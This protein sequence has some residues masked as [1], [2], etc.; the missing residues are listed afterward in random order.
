M[1]KHSYEQLQHSS[2]LSDGN[3]PY[4]EDLYEE[5]LKDPQAVGEKWRSYFESVL[6]GSIRSSEISRREIEEQFIQ[7]AKEPKKIFQT[8]TFAADDLSTARQEAVD[9]LITAYRRFGHLNA[10]IDPLGVVQPI[11]SRLTLEHYGLSEK[12]FSEK[13]KTRGL[14]KETVMSLQEI[15][16]ALRSRYCSSIGIEYSRI[17]D[18]AEREWLC[19]YA[20]HR[21]MSRSFDPAVKLHILKKLIAAEGL[22]KHLDSKYPGV[23]RFSAEG[24]DSI[25]PL[26]DEI[27]QKSR[28][29]GLHELVIGMAHRGRLNVLLNI[30][31]QSPEELFQEFEGK[32]DYGMTT[33][34]V[35]YHR[36]FSSDVATPAGPVHLSLMF[37]PSHLE[38]VNPVVIGSVRGRQDRAPDE[39]KRDYAMAILIHG[40]AAFA[41]LGIV[42]E[43]LNM[44]QTRA[45]TTGGTIHIV[46]NNQVGFTTSNAQDSRSSHYC[47]DIARMIDAPIV[48]VNGDDPEAVVA[49]AAMALEYRVKFHKD[50]VI[51]L[52][53]YRRHG[54]QE[55][56]EPRI[57]QPMMYQII[58]QHSSPRELY[59]QK[60][61]KEQ[62]VTEVEANQWLTDYRNRL[63][64]GRQVVETM[65][66]GLCSRYAV[67]WAPFLDQNP[68]IKVDTSVPLGKIKTLAKE[69][70]KIPSHF[71]LHRSVEAIMQARQKMS[72]GELP[73]DWG[74]A[75]IMAYATL[76]DQGYP[77]RMS[78]ED[79]RRG[80]FFHRHAF[81][82]DQ[83]TGAAY[84]PLAHL[85]EQQAK[86]QI[87]DSV[88]A[89]AGPMGF[90]YGYSTAEPNALVIW[91]AQFGDFANVAQVIIDQ[92]ISSGWQKWRRLS[93]LTLFLPHGNEGL[94]PEHSSARLERFLQLCAQHNMQVFIPSTPA[95]MF[96][97]LR[98]QVLRPLRIPL[99]VMTPKS[100]LRHKLSVSSL[101]DLVKDQ[102]KLLI[103][104][105]D[106]D[107]K[108]AKVKRVVFCSGKIYFELLAMRREKEIKDIALV[109]IEQLYPFP[110]EEVIEVMKEYSKAKEV[111]WCQDEPKNQGA[112]F[113]TRDRLLKCLPADKE[114]ICVSRPPM[115][116]PAAGYPLLH[117]KDQEKVINQTLN[118]E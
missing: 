16:G 112:W 75:E 31:G 25:I 90:E 6:K 39:S 53:C 34:D 37:N 116:A 51:D 3:A 95:Q 29:S 13:F 4:I 47:T 23:R 32:K 115:A 83:I 55:V 69:L 107:I 5:Y 17:S 68:K 62:L 87:Y 11:D 45:Y 30:M 103:P 36:G 98:R 117:K 43:T 48:H 67:N 28:A 2:Y 18:E 89:E 82:F 71:K 15:Y 114:L 78:G 10:K 21:L 22:E 113:C 110:Y 80:T 59:I 93:G 8:T 108:P 86:A 42:M 54:H 40:D 52:V 105:I 111:V 84:M 70:E 97:L 94:G 64:E 46:I 20:E 58:D 26:L 9:S 49:V 65:S 7:L 41:G 19:D 38:F 96:H 76:L 85:G 92:F 74:Y 12:N 88:L 109:R 99:V 101:D 79:C 61:V 27:V 81:V 63:D 33:G 100:L 50:F 91:E 104:E 72:A 57:T 73:I 102:L 106:E 77:V 66:E 60:L 56:D 14:L 1:K 118:L 24:C 35:K 44:S